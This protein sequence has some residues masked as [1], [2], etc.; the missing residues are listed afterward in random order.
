MFQGKKDEIPGQTNFLK[1]PTL[2]NFFNQRFGKNEEIPSQR[3][4]LNLT[5]VEFFNASFGI[6]YSWNYISINYVFT[7]L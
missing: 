5:N 7:N 4:F 3:H 2:W 6:A 1:Q